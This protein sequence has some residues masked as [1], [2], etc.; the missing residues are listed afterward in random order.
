MEEIDSVQNS[1]E[2]NRPVCSIACELIAIRGGLAYLWVE[3]IGCIPLG[4]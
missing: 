3:G 1:C 2:G 4:R